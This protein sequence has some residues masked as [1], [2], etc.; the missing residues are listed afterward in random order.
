MEEGLF[1][2]PQ[3]LMSC[4]AHLGLPV[5]FLGNVGWKRAGSLWTRGKGG[6]VMGRCKYL[7]LPYSPF[8]GSGR[9]ISS[10]FL[11]HAIKRHFNQ[12]MIKQDF[13]NILWICHP[14]FARFACQT[15]PDL[16]VYDIMDRFAGFRASPSD[17]T[18]QEAEAYTRADL[19][20]AGGHSLAEAA[21]RDLGK[22]GIEKP[23]YCFPSGVDL[24]HFA[25]NIELDAAD[26]GT[27]GFLSRPVLGYFGAV[28]ERIDFELLAEVARM[29]PTWSIVLIGPVITAIPPLPANICLVGPR[30]YAELPRLMQIFDVSLIPFRQT[31]LVAHVSPTKTPEYL[32]GGK[33]VI[34]TPIPDVIHDYGDVVSIAEN[35]S[36]LVAEVEKL[37]AEPPDPQALREVAKT[38]A[39][40]WMAI[41]RQM[42]S[43]VEKTLRERPLSPRGEKSVRV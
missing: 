26:V 42:I 40:T 34:S 4:F 29:R 24:D 16:V 20:F 22:L 9:Q 1:Q 27:L 33:P 11:E 39:R 2:R 15:D 23:V 3:Q 28:D 32:A 36:E 7:H 8:G 41:A 38:R 21:R 6:G 13:A 19:I 10:L 30:S 25:R 18:R 5:L 37:L 14:S 31:E 17:I 43:L 35:A 12:Q